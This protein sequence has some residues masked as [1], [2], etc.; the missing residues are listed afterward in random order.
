MAAA[1]E[2][3]MLA[4]LLALQR[5]GLKVR[6]CNF[7]KH[8]GCDVK[9]VKT[10]RSANAAH[11]H[12]VSRTDIHLCVDTSDTCSVYSKGYERL[13]RGKSFAAAVAAIKK[14]KR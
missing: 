2:T 14:G 5:A 4:L 6:I 3:E 8:T 7:Y 13:Y 9:V 12:F 11:V 10:A 1:F